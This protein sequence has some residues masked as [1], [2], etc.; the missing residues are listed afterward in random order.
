MLAARRPGA[1]ARDSARKALEEYES[2]LS[3]IK[4]ET[5]RYHSLADVAESARLAGSDEK[6]REY[7]SELLRRAKSFPGLELRQRG[8]R[9]APILGHL[10]LKAGTS[11]VRRSTLEGRRHL[12]ASLDSFGPELSLASELLARR[13]VGHRL[14][15]ADLALLEGRKRGSRRIILIQAGKTPSGTASAPAARR[16]EA[17]IRR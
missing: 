9:R 13:A 3:L 4:D 14:P 8:A 17:S 5:K 7:A 6:A 15:P 2:A 10:E 16:A 1:E 11:R 12:A